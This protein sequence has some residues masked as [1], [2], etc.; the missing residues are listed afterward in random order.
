MVILA[1]SGVVI[2]GG[3]SFAGQRSAAAVRRGNTA[4][5]SFVSLWATRHAIEVERFSLATGKPAQ[6]LVRDAS[7]LS[8]PQPGPHGLVWL[9]PQGT[10]GGTVRTLDPRSGHTHLVERVAAS[11]MVNDAVPDPT[12]KRVVQSAVS[13]S[14]PFL[15]EHYVVRDLHSGRSWTLGADARR[16]HSLSTPSWNAT[17]SQL[18]FTYGA[19]RLSARGGAAAVG[20]AGRGAGGR[21]GGTGRPSHCSVPQRAKIVVVSA[22]HRSKASSWRILARR[23]GCAYTSAAFDAAG[24]VAFQACAPNPGDPTV[25][26]FMGPAYAVQLNLQG[27]VLFRLPLKI[28]SNPG[29]IA[30]DLLSGIV[31][32]SQNQ[33][34][35]AHTPTHNFVWQLSG[36]RLRLVGRYSFTGV[37][38]IDAHPLSEP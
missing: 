16:C 7:Q 11:E 4:A 24:I 38:A 29:S 20:S 1:G 3:T 19:S 30:S 13:C 33:T 25:D 22:L 36:R 27:R 26:D 28:G 31:L 17:G 34:V 35:R 2:A 8:E 6:T 23:A 15:N 10:C 21:R 18:V 5:G 14:N 9:S 37:G 32:I 12:G